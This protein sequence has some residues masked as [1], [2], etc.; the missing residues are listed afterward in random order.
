M[1]GQLRNVH[2][3]LVSDS[4]Q[5]YGADMVGGAWEYVFFFYYF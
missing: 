5:V 2:V 4:S 1:D 3:V